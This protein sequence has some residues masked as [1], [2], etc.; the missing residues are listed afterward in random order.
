MKEETIKKTLQKWNTELIDLIQER[1]LID[2]QK[3]KLGDKIS[4]LSTKI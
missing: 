4:N 1:N 3:R 2:I